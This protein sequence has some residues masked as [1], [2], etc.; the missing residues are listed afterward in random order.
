MVR[1]RRQ[2]RIKPGRASN[3]SGWEYNNPQSCLRKRLEN[4]FKK[5][6]GSEQFC[7]KA[8]KCSMG[9][10]GFPK[11]ISHART[12]GNIM[13]RKAGISVSKYETDRQIPRIPSFFFQPTQMS[14]AMSGRTTA[15][16][17]IELYRI[18]KTKPAR[19]PSKKESGRVF[20]CSLHASQTQIRA[21]T[22][23]NSPE[24]ERRCSMNV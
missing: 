15:K 18:S 17:I 19:T 3:Q 13:R 12:C 2:K 21:T 1:F 4:I 20:P 7:E 23:K 16:I 22:R 10:N 11:I 14:D 24:C 9:G 5:R 6:V 8:P